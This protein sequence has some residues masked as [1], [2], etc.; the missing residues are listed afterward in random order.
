MEK[1]IEMLEERERNA[2]IKYR[3]AQNES[4]MKVLGDTMES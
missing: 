2:S 3:S 4:D 1:E